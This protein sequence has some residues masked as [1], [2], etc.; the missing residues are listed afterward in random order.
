MAAE[1]GG[2]KKEH[3][4]VLVLPDMGLSESEVDDLKGRFEN[5]IIESMGGRQAR[6]DVVVVV[7]VVV[8]FAAAEA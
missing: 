6:P 1:Y 5:Q 7:V 8:V 3:K 4:A 2:K